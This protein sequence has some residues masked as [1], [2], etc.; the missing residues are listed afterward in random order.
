M[1]EYWTI[2]VSLELHTNTLDKK[3]DLGS[4]RVGGRF[5]F[6]VPDFKINIISMVLVDIPYGDDWPIEENKDEP[7][8]IFGVE[9]MFD[10]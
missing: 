4:V 7:S 3:D 1:N 9:A 8:F 10:F 6:N 2:G 5:Y